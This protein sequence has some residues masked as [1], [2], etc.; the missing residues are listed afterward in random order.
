MEGIRLSDAEWEIMEL[1][2][3]APEQS[4]AQVVAAARAAGRD[5]A[6][7]TVQTF[8]T[9]LRKK[10]A[11]EA[12]SAG[13]KLLY[14]ARLTREEAER[15]EAGRL[16]RRVFG[17]SARALVSSLLQSETLSREE[18]EQLRRVID[19]YQAGGGARS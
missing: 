8:L 9:R 19:E 12:R 11:A 6:P 15:R 3:L 10:G 18:L 2:W 13:G 16:Y 1:L 5:W 4:L 17:S 7:N 14:R